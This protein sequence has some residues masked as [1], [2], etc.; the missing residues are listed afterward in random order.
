MFREEIDML[1]KE[2]KDVKEKSKSIAY[3][4]VSF[5]KNIIIGLLIF[6]LLNNVMWFLYLTEF[7]YSYDE[8]TQTQDNVSNSQIIGEIN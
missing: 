7:D 2:V 8:L 3:E 1:K 5:L 6:I 4:M